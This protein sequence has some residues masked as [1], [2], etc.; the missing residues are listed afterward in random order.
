MCRTGWYFITGKTEYSVCEYTV[1]QTYSSDS[2]L[3]LQVA[4]TVQT[5]YSCRM[6]QALQA[7]QARLDQ[8]QRQVDEAFRA[9]EAS[10]SSDLKKDRYEPL[11]LSLHKS[12]D[13]VNNLAATAWA[14]VSG[15]QTYCAI[16]HCLHILVNFVH[17]S[18]VTAA[19]KHLCLMHIYK[20]P[21]RELYIDDIRFTA[22]RTGKLNAL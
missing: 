16:H 2:A 3:M 18:R 8:L 17:H 5:L 6:V 15:W 9:Y 22:D 4:C 11:I 20:V 12:E 21:K 1:S 10:P 19:V 7:A 14:N 13:V